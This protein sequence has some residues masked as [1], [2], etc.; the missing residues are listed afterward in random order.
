MG[1]EKVSEIVTISKSSEDV[2]KDFTL[3]FSSYTKTNDADTIDAAVTA[4][5]E[6]GTLRKQDPIDGDA[7]SSVYE[8]E[9][10]DLTKEMDAEYSLTLDSDISNA[11]EDIKNDSSPKLAAQVIDKTLQRVFLSGSSGK[12]YSCP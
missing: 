6:I 3:N 5:S 1:Y 10:Q 9:L 2:E 4:F 8:G 12:H 7:I 11:V